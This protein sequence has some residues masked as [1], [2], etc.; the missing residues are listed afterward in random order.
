MKYS[1]FLLADKLSGQTLK[2]TSEFDVETFDGPCKAPEWLVWNEKI[3]QKF[4]D[5]QGW[6][7]SNRD[8]PMAAHVCRFC[9]EE[10]KSMV[11]RRCCNKD[12]NRLKRDASMGDIAIHQ[13]EIFNPRNA[14]K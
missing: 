8:I 14:L 2:P 7:K 4:P 5:V 13:S 6:A 3:T 11:Q 9:D 1:F 10:L 12:N